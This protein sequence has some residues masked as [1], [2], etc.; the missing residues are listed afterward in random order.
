MTL[1]SSLPYVSAASA[2]AAA[3]ATGPRTAPAERALKCAAFAALALYAYLRW[4]AP[5]EAALALTLAAIGQAAL[6]RAG[7][8]VAVAFSWLV[9][10]WLFYQTGDGAGVLVTDAARAAMFAALVL[11]AALALRRLWRAPP[12]PR[13][14]VLAAALSLFLMAAGAV[15]LD[16]S[17]WPAIGG[18]FAIVLAQ[19]ANLQAAS[20]PPLAGEAPRSDGGDPGEAPRS[21]GGGLGGGGLSEP[22]RTDGRRPARLR[23]AAWAVNFLGHAA[24]AYAFMK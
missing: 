6:P 16:W 18:A 11:A 12:G 15:T 9:F 13:P 4:I 7:A 20:P 24:V 21:D 14:A 22:P 1:E 8:F 5:T 3:L 23:R 2:V 10:A 17:F 19:L